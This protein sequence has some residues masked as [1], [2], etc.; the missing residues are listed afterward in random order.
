MSA[1]PKER[2]ARLRDARW[3]R[4]GA[5]RSPIVSGGA[6]GTSG[7]GMVTG[8]SAA[9]P[10]PSSWAMLA[11]GFAGLALAG[12]GRALAMAPDDDGSP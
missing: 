4:F 8:F 10:E 1:G 7:Y 5:A 12:A 3:G 9:I 2:P 11:L 6:G